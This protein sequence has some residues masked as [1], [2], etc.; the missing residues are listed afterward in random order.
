MRRKKLPYIIRLIRVSLKWTWRA[1]IMIP[2]EI[3]SGTT[4]TRKKERQYR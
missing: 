4:P 2:K 1:M 3:V